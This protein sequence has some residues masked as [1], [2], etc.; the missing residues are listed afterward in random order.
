[1]I[2]PSWREL[3]CGLLLVVTWASI[4]FAIGSALYSEED[5]L[6]A[7]VWHPWFW[8]DEHFSKDYFYDTM[9]QR[10]RSEGLKRG[11]VAGVRA[12]ESL[13][14]KPFLE[15]STLIG[16]VR[17]N[18]LIPWDTDADFGM[19]EADCVAQGLTKDRVQA[20]IDKLYPPPSSTESTE[21]TRT[22]TTPRKHS[23][24]VFRFQCKIEKEAADDK[25]DKNDRVLGLLTDT[26]TGA[27]VDIFMYRPP[28]K[29]REWQ[30]KASKDIKWL[31]RANDEHADYTFPQNVLLPLQQRSFLNTTLYIPNQPEEFL[32]WEYGNCLGVHLFPYAFFVY[33]SA[34]IYVYWFLCFIEIVLYRSHFGALPAIALSMFG[35][36][37]LAVFLILIM[38]FIRQ[39]NR[40]LFLAFFLI[41]LY[42]L[43]A[44][45]FQLQCDIASNVVGPAYRPRTFTICLFGNCWDFDVP[46]A[47]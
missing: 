16:Y 24:E 25:N 46:S 32:K 13:G 15:S 28:E 5:I 2:K 29:L 45:L 34:T 43:R 21:S 35:N 17:H 7:N 12:I 26:Q 4:K 36:S 37:G 39:K 3:V 42:D 38:Q 44:C 11:I 19:L 41:G 40:Y 22:T 18:D 31:E 1:M 14:V 47:L 6:N 30:E 20:A 10:T 33:S 8:T 27:T 9:A 23:I